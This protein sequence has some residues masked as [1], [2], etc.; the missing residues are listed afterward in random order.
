MSP[1][2]VALI[3]VIPD[4]LLS[5]GRAMTVGCEEQNTQNQIQVLHTHSQQYDMSPL[6]LLSEKEKKAEH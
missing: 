6:T 3:Y 2:R 5:S 4:P 1:G